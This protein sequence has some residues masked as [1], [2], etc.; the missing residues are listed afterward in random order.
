[1]ATVALLF[2]LTTGTLGLAFGPLR[3]WVGFER[4]ALGLTGSVLVLAVVSLVLVRLGVYSP[5]LAGAS[6][7]LLSGVAF[8][9]SRRWPAQATVESR[10]AAP[11]ELWIVTPLLVLLFCLYVFFPTYFVL[12]GQDPGV[13]LAFSAHISK[14]GGLALDLSWLRSLAASHPQ[15]L[16]LGYPGIY[17][18]AEQ[19]GGSDVAQLSPQFVH[20]FPALMANAWG[21]FGLEGAVRI[22]GLLSVLALSIGYALVRRLVGFGAAVTFVLAMGL[23][24][25]FLWGARI[26]LTETLALLINLT[27]LLLFLV[28][29]TRASRFASFAGGIVL[30]V[31]LFNRL[32]A[33]LASI[34]I[35]GLGTASIVD[36]SLS[37]FAR[38]AA[39]SF[40]ITGSIGVADACLHAPYYVAALSRSSHLVA[41]LGGNMALAA[42]VLCVPS[43]PERWRKHLVPSRALVLRLCEQAVI[44]TAAWVLL[45]LLAWPRIDPGQDARAA[46]ELTWY[47]TP[48]A[49]P[50]ALLGSW[51]LVRTD[52]RALPLVA[53]GLASVVLFTLETHVAPQHIWASRRWL[54]QV[55]PS[56]LILS[57]VAAGWIAHLTRHR[58]RLRAFVLTLPA[59]AYFVP[60]LLFDRPFAFRSMLKGLPAA[61][62]AVAARV[63]TARI[64]PP[65]VTA[66]P[67]LASIFTYVYDL[68]VVL[69]GGEGRFGSSSEVAE[70]LLLRG[71]LEG[72]PAIGLD[73]FE[74]GNTPSDSSR[75]VGDY[76][77]MTETRPPRALIELPVTLDVGIIGG[78][79]RSLEVPAHHPRLTSNIGV[80][81]PGGTLISDG[82]AGLLQGGPCM[83]V[84]PGTY[85]VDW[86]GRVLDPGGPP[87]QQGTIDVVA[88]PNQTV[89]TSMPF[90][91]RATGAS[92]TWLTGLDFSTGRTLRCVEFRLQVK[93][94]VTMA[95]SRLRLKRTAPAP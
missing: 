86:I 91:L 25:A 69:M 89:V 24:P 84:G 60:T 71:D 32:D 61:Y 72:L 18:L 9:A 13:Y 67:N 65:L 87:K 94:G 20:L 7:A 95:L 26:T 10:P 80:P 47:A 22:N 59:F 33:S 3:L 2:A 40:L 88:A 19:S 5:G 4:W 51:R 58:L 73:A 44:L 53:L 17:G 63:R 6:S 38:A 90:R 15:G 57:L 77:E 35:A 34:A 54:P 56:M 27:G 83:S 8:A 41:F 14:T 46:R 64:E 68:P 28:A 50:L 82:N 23:N 37:R 21:A 31:G 49:W 70:Q 81:G 55:I 16:A 42:V 62:E 92:E 78:P 85:A 36:R 48:V 45:A 66:N 74:L 43:I 79:G 75:F 76:L 93:Q 29:T 30:G 52:P 39:G 12:G 11:V 1:V